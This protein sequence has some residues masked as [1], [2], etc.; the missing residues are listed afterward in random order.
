MRRTESYTTRRNFQS[1]IKCTRSFKGGPTQ[2]HTSHTQSHA[3]VRP[4]RDHRP[5]TLRISD[6]DRAKQAPPG[7]SEPRS[8]PDPTDPPSRASEQACTSEHQPTNQP[9]H[10]K[11]YPHHH[12][13]RAHT[14]TT[15][16]RFSVRRP[17]L[18]R[19]PSVAHLPGTNR[20]RLWNTSRSPIFSWPRAC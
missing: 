3:V 18:L 20:L 9:A 11:K 12:H 17:T 15:P 7:P 19:C 16:L 13:H 10:H 8:L 1:I 5:K 14:I 2:P 4:Q 6:S